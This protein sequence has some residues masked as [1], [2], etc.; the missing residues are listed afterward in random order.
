MEKPFTDTQTWMAML[1]Y[2]QKDAGQAHYRY[3]AVGVSAAEAARARDAYTTVALTYNQGGRE[4][5][6]ANFGKLLYQVGCAP[7]RC[8]DSALVAAAVGALRM[9][10]Q[11]GTS[12]TLLFTL[13]PQFWYSHINPLSRRWTSSPTTPLSPAS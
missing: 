3:I 7:P 1:G 10:G 5:N 6:K 13:P 4:L 11:L 12:P 9:L 8:S 2:C